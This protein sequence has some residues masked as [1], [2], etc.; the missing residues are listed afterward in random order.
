[1]AKTML[2]LYRDAC[3]RNGVDPGTQGGWWQFCAGWDAKKNRDKRRRVSRLKV[4]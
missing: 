2:E 4:R 1:M 3:K